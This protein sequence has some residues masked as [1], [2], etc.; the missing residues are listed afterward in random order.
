MPFQTPVDIGNRALQ[1]LGAIRIDPLVG[2]SENS[3]NAAAISFCYD[4]LRQAELRR[5]FW[6]FSITKTVL[7]P[8][9]LTTMFLAPALWASTTAYNLGSLVTDTAGA[10]WMSQQAF[11]LNNAPGNSLLWELYTGPLTLDAF[12]ETLKTAYSA[13]ELVY[14][15]PGDGTVKVYMSLTNANSDDPENTITA[16][17]STVEYFKGQ[18]IT[19]S[20]TSYQSLID[21]NLN[22]SPPSPAPW[23]VGTTYSTGNSVSGSDGFNYT[24]IGNGN[25]GHDPTVD[26]GVHW[27]ATNVLTAWQSVS[28]SG[29]VNWLLLTVALQDI[30]VLWPVGS[31]PTIQT[32]TKNAYRLPAGFLREAPQSPKQGSSS[33]LGAPSGRMYEDWVYSGKYIVTNQLGPLIYRFVADISNVNNMDPMFCEGLAAR[34][35]YETCEEITQSNAK[36][37]TC[38]E[39]YKRSMSEARTVNAIEQGPIEPPEDD[40]ITCR[41]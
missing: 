31:G 20:G 3:R 1:H 19:F 32:A 21:F 37:Q 7:R 36:Q 11:N 41:I 10:I 17:S 16:W 35:G 6:T 2:F 14:D 23:L 9:T 22:N 13:G 18:T 12:D 15:T 5:N 29:S 26:G 4:K 8:L 39:A 33:F 38:L 27:T 25:V 28:A 40:Y 24:S 30:P 34:I